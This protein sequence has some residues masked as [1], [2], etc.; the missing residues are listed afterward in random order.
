MILFVEVGTKLV[1][2]RVQFG[3]R[4]SR[5]RLHSGSNSIRPACC[6]SSGVSKPS[7]SADCVLP[8]FA[9]VLSRQF[10]SHSS[11]KGALAQRPKKKSWLIGCFCGGRLVCMVCNSLTGNISHP[12]H[13]HSS[14]FETMAYPPAPAWK[15]VFGD[16]G[17]VPTRMALSAAQL[18]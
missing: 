12:E 15:N 11:G 10:C 9:D 16:G 7:S 1:Y 2:S 17:D 6:V 4:Q 8:G 13:A 18:E 14:L 3:T 5:D